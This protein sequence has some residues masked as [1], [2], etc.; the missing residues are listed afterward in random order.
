M[1]RRLGGVSEPG[2]LSGPWVR[3]PVA[4]LYFVI[5]PPVPGPACPLGL[6]FDFVAK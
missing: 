2:N 4:G 1:Y 3:D 6:V 5:S